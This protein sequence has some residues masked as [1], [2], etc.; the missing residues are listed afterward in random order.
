MPTRQDMVNFIRTQMSTAYQAIGQDH[1]QQWVK[2]LLFG[3]EDKWFVLFQSEG[4]NENFQAVVNNFLNLSNPDTGWTDAEKQANTIAQY[5]GYLAKALA[6]VAMSKAELKQLQA[7]LQ[8]TT[9]STRRFI[10]QTEITG[11]LAVIDAQTQ[12]ANTWQVTLDNLLVG[13][14]SEQAPAKTTTPTTPSSPNES[15]TSQEDTTQ[16]AKP[17]PQEA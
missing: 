3:I 14:V 4:G 5:Q 15:T 6:V 17:A 10:L 1:L 9:D 8:A 2:G 7:E 12:N 16:P 13:K 11:Q